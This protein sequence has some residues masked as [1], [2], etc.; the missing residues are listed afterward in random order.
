M[1][2]QLSLCR[3]L[4]GSDSSLQNSKPNSQ[5]PSVAGRWML[6][7]GRELKS[8]TLA[9]NPIFVEVRCDSIPQSRW[10]CVCL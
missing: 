5:L 6:T 1:V 10:S 9:K 4:K 2:R 8:E 7:V 3:L